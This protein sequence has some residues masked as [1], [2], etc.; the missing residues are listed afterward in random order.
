MRY[1]YTRMCVYTQ[2]HTMEYYS[3]IKR[4]EIVPFAATWMD[5]EGITLSE[6][7]QT[8]RQILYDVTYV[9]NLK[10]YNKVVNI[11][12]RSRLTYIENKLVVTSGER[13]RRGNIGVG[14]QEVQTIGCKIGSRIYCTTWEIQ[15]IF[16]NDCKW[17]VTFKNCIKNN[18]IIRKNISE[19]NP[20]ISERIM[21][22]NQ[23]EFILEM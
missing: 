9:Q 5:L 18:N 23:V 6:I 16:C 12:K 21:H 4:N 10:K 15:P 19:L 14:E 3:A 17:S 11:T 2:T 13:E 20:V 8:E 1:I 7:S 22:N